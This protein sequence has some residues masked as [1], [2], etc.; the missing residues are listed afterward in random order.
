MRGDLSG[1]GEG[2][3]TPRFEAML[4]RD[5]E[6]FLAAR[7]FNRKDY[8]FRRTRGVMYDLID[9]QG[10]W[11]NDERT[12]HGFFVNVGVGSTEVDAPWPGPRPDPPIGY[13]LSRR[14]EDVVPGLPYEPSFRATTNMTR[15]GAALC[16]GLGEV[17]DV[18]ERFDGTTSLVAYA[19]DRNLL[20]AYE[21]T[22]CYLAA[23][24]DLD[25]LADYVR[26]LRDCFGHQER[27]SIFNANISAVAGAHRTSLVAL[28]L[29][30][31][32]AVP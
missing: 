3:L 13:L 5:V 19:V 26:Q 6:P 12:W 28:G 29:L 4:T 17:V 32:V 20:I 10:D 9:F 25:T 24:D 8:A 14:W 22:C 15:F 18:I 16:Q 7:G 2:P 23:V 21:R 1:R 31:E 11:Y 27:W 30:D